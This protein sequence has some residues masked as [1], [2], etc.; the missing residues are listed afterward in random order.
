MATCNSSARSQASF[1]LSTSTGRFR[2]LFCIR[3]FLQSSD[4]RAVSA[5]VH[6]DEPPARSCCSLCFKFG[7]HC[8]HLG[9]LPHQQYSMGH[10]QLGLHHSTEPSFKPGFSFHF[11]FPSRSHSVHAL[12]VHCAFLTAQRKP[13]PCRCSALPLSFILL[14]R[15]SSRTLQ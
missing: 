13:R 7:A 15:A 11:T 1:L 12:L 5:Q 14:L 10:F 6:T 8:I 2:R 4:N 9:A 3:I